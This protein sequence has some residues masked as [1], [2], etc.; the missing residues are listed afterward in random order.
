[1]TVLARCLEFSGTDFR[2]D[3]NVY[4]RSIEVMHPSTSQS[5]FRHPSP[6]LCACDVSEALHLS[7]SFFTHEP[8]STTIDARFDTNLQL[9][10]IAIITL[11]VT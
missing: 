11:L 4:H 6:W 9:H 1:M 7:L 8:T 3:G 5:N 2:F 10:F